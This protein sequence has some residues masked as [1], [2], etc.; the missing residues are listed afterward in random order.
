MT[1]TLRRVTFWAL[2][3][4]MVGG[5]F[6]RQVL[7]VNTPAL[8]R[9]VMF[10]GYGKDVCEVR[11]FIPGE[12]GTVEPVDRCAVLGHEDCWTAP[13]GVKVLE[14]LDQVH[15]QAE[16]LCRKLGPEVDLRLISRCGTFQGWVPKHSGRR[17]IC[18]IVEELREKERAR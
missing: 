7:R 12:D 18:A 9:W 4:F 6:A 3:L 2:V 1:A 16:Q 11:F 5:P 17:S 13:R 8:R 15:R 10:S 14:G